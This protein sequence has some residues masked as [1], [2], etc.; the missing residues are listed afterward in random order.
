MIMAQP[1]ERGKGYTYEDYLTWNDGRRWEIID[2]VAYE[3]IE[4]PTIVSDMT[5]GPNR[6][7]QLI[8]GRLFGVIFNFLTGKKA[9][10]YSAPFDIVLRMKMCQRGILL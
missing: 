1:I 4:G 7:H 10:I 8:S 9:Q 6:D 2:G 5:P 3:K